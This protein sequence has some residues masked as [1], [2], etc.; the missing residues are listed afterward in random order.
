MTATTKRAT[1]TALPKAKPSADTV[2]S[3]APD[4]K[5]A[6]SEDYSELLVAQAVADTRLAMADAKG[7]RRRIKPPQT[8]LRS[9]RISAYRRADYSPAPTTPG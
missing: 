6:L 8:L 5:S 2:A 3:N 7:R 9:K 1:A 4:P